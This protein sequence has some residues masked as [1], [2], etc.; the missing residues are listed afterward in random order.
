LIGRCKYRSMPAQAPPRCTNCS[1]THQRPVYQSPYC[2]VRLTENS[3]NPKTLVST[4]GIPYFYISMPLLCQTARQGHYVLDLSVCPSVRPSVRLFV[5]RYFENEWT[6]F[7]DIGTSGPRKKHE[8]TINIGSQEVKVQGHARPKIHF[9]TWRR[10]AL[11]S[12]PLSR[13]RL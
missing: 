8:K 1:V 6:D 9:E 11:F 5:T 13:V 12:T 7:D 10:R 4:L 3:S 2:C